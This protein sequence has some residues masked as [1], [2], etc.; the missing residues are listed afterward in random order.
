MLDTS[1][2]HSYKYSE[3]VFKRVSVVTTGKNHGL[4]MFIDFSGSMDRN[5]PGTIDQLMIL[6]S[7]CR[8]VN[9]PFEV[10]SFTD[11]DQSSFQAKV[12]P[13]NRWTSKPGE[14]IM[15]RDFTM[16]QYFSSTMKA[17]EYNE[18]LLNMM[19]LR[20][21]FTTGGILNGTHNI[22]AEDITGGTP[23]NECI[24]AARKMVPAFR[25]KYGLQVV[26]TV[27]LTDGASN[28]MT[29]YV[30]EDDTPISLRGLPFIRD[31]QTRKEY[32]G[33]MTSALLNALKDATGAHAIG[34]FLL[35]SVHSVPGLVKMA[36]DV[37][38]DPKKASKEFTDT[39]IFPIEGSCAIGFEPYF[40][41]NA[42]A[43]IIREKSLGEEIKN[44]GGNV[45][46]AFTALN[47]RKNIDR[48]VSTK[49]IDK[50]TKEF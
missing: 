4:M 16:R 1:K 46:A 37:K 15:D 33:D 23:L 8:R 34:F 39:G 42:D 32:E 38:I 41:L 5:M 13:E 18:A 21:A 29:T 19:C 45:G 48:Q 17:H 47:R 44:S 50:I 24:I 27:F 10:F 35:G 7:F 6:T 28:G 26:N 11:N 36:S 2:L 22:P 31:M 49:F 12:R 43:L 30:N 20:R 9:I 14:F 25:R 3:D 40:L